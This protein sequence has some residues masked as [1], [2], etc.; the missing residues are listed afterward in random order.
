MLGVSLVR[1]STF[2]WVR[3][4]EPPLRPMVRTMISKVAAESLFAHG[5]CRYLKV[6]FE[7][8]LGRNFTLFFF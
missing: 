5:G 8:I 6:M 2:L 7:T 3:Q 4:P 1:V